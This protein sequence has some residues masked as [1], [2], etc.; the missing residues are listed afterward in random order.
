MR[1]LKLMLMLA[2]VV[3]ISDALA[4]APSEQGCNEDNNGEL[5][6]YTGVEYIQAQGVAKDVA[7]AFQ[8]FQKACDLDIPDGCNVLGYHYQNGID[9]AVDYRVA[10]QHYHGACAKGL[11][12]ACKWANALLLKEEYGIQDK[13][14][15]PAVW[16]DACQSGLLEMC[17]WGIDYLT[18]GKDGYAQDRDAAAKMSLKAC[19]LQDSFG[20][21]MAEYLYASPDSPQFDALEA[22]RILS[23]NCIQRKSASCLRL[24][25]IYH[26][27]EVYDKAEFF[28][29]QACDLPEEEGNS[30]KSCQY[31]QDLR[32]YFAKEAARQ[33]RI[34]ELQ[35]LEQ[36]RLTRLNSLLAAR[37]YAGAMHYAVETRSVAIAERAVA[38]IERAGA[39][40]NIG[41]DSLY[42]MATWLRGSEL[43]AVNAEMRRR[44][45][46]LEGQFG[47]GTNT[48]AQIARRYAE[49]NGGRQLPSANVSASNFTP[50]AVPSSAS[51][52]E[53]TKQKYRWAH[54]QMAGSNTNATVCN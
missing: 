35:A 44:G 14:A 6:F 5:C 50:I 45:T 17:H 37:D 7:K 48:P 9:V 28:Y 33:Q 31:A 53:A 15:V 23:I 39:W 3:A 4:Q 25:V 43:A 41:V 1:L 52:A 46:G 20:C 54:C 42:I 8:Y 34:A 36:E 47:E 13:T 49:A 2:F 51:I 11:T 29:Q 32:D 18:D 22:M 19:M 40:S 21:D 30:H 27:I 12:D 38:V 16:F 10:A 26:Q 24:G